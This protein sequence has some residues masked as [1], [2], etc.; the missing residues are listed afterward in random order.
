MIVKTWN[1]GRFNTSGAGYGIRIPKESREKHFNKTWEYVTLKIADKSIDI[2][3][4]ATFWTTCSE[5]RSKVIGQFLIKNNVGTW[6]KG[7][8]H[9]LH[10]EIFEDNIFVLRKL[11]TYKSTK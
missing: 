4:R 1:N 10:L 9:E 8:P 6:G 7:H 5:L 11:D 2:K 3:L